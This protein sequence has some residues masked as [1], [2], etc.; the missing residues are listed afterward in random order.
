MAIF[1]FPSEWFEK[2]Y[3]QSHM[4]SRICT[5]TYVQSHMYSPYVQSEKKRKNRLY[6]IFY[7]ESEFHI[8]KI[9]I[10]LSQQLLIGF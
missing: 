1:F 4:Y 10:D 2:T 8:F 3:V 9:K 7:A 6:T 5:V